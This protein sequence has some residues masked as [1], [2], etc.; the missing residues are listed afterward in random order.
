MSGRTEDQDR[1]AIAKVA[2]K[3]GDPEAFAER[4]LRV[5]QDLQAL[6][7]GTEL[8]AVYPHRDADRQIWQDLRET[9]QNVL[10][11]GWVASLDE[12]DAQLLLGLIDARPRLERTGP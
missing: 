4:E 6:P 5:L 9:L 12:L 2:N 7:I 10:L 8:F 1:V 11:H 3:H